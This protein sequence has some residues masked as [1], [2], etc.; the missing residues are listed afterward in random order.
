MER[1]PAAFNFADYLLALNAARGDKPAYIDD[2]RRLSYAELDRRVRRFAAA[3]PGLGLHREE[4][5][6]LLMHDCV[7]WPVAFLGCLQAG[8]VPV[9]VNTLLPAQD[10]AWMLGHSGARAVIT[11]TPLLAAAQAALAA[12]GRPL[13]LIVAAA[14][15]E[16][17]PEAAIRFA[18]LA[19]AGSDGMAPAAA[20]S[21]DDIAFW[22]YSSG[23]TGTPK[24]TVH[25]HGNLFMTAATYG[26]HVLKLVEGDVTFSAAKLFFAYGLGNSLSFP[27]SV[28]ATV[29]LLGGRPTPDAVFEVLLRHRP[30]VFFGV[31]TLYAGMLASPAL[32]AA[33]ALCLRR[34]T[35]AGEALPKEVGERFSAHVGAPILDG[36]GST[37]MLHIYLSNRDECLRY[38]TTGKPVP[39]YEIRLVNE[40]GEPAADGEIGELHVRG[41]SA[42]LMYW[43]NR[44]KSRST[45]LGDWL[46]SGDKYVRDT[47]GWYTYAGRADD[48]LKVSGQYLSPFEIE[49]GLMAHAAVLEAAVIGTEDAHGLTRCKAFVV[50]KAGIAASSQL[51]EELRSFLKTRLAPHKVPREITV[52]DELPKTPTGKIQRYR[53]RERERERA[54]AG[55]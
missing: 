1:P 4:R 3:L 22:L 42:A 30:T 33:G 5:V 45:F 16:A 19:E 2:R 52:L 9:A 44:D 31:P 32:P 29:L 6:L 40:H 35:S 8:V 51:H 21:R 49:S 25:T 43:T 55:A 20:T 37:E 48:M 54:A 24:G 38:G 28:G 7:D 41:D 18:A 46:K 39:G 15:D 26:R 10:Y 17:L 27:L 13:P 34:C 36:I 14:P 23:S 50:L 11:S 12:S 53:L 47:Q